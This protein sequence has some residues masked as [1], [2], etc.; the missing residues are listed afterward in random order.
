MAVF[1]RQTRMRRNVA[2]IVSAAAVAL[3]AVWQAGA[4]A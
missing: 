1:W 2:I 3:A 4:A